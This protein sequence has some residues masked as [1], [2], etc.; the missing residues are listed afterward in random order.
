M[1]H[2]TSGALAVSYLNVFAES[3]HDTVVRGDKIRW[4]QSGGSTPR[5]DH[6]FR[7]S[8]DNSD[9]LDLGFIDRKE[10]IIIFEKDD[11]IGSDL[12]Q[13]R[14]V[15]FALMGAFLSV[16][17]QDLPFMISPHKDP[18]SRTAISWTHLWRRLSTS[19]D[20][21][22]D[23]QR[24]FLDGS[25]SDFPCVDRSFGEI[26]GPPLAG[27]GHLKVESG[28][29]SGVDAIRPEPVAHEHPVESPLLTDDVLE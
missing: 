26:K 3:V 9:L 15:F 7:V 4:L 28:V 22:E 1:I 6:G 10:P 11:G 17:V 24:S 27:T 21:L 14:G 12:P 13:E 19:L 18:D 25:D 23:L 20:Q 8:T 2:H 5:Q 16:A 29:D